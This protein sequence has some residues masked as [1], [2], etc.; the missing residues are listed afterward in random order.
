MAARACAECAHAHARDTRSLRSLVGSPE[1]P[2]F[3][4]QDATNTTKTIN[5]HK[6]A[7]ESLARFARSCAPLRL[8]HSHHKTRPTPPRQSTNTSRHRNHSLASLARVLPCGSN[9]PTTRRD[10]HH[11]DN[12]T[13]QAGAGITRS[14]RSLVCSPAA[15]TFPPQDVTR[16]LRSL[17]CSPADPHSLR[18]PS[19]SRPRSARLGFLL[20]ARGGNPRTPSA[21]HGKGLRNRPFTSLG[22]I[23]SGPPPSRSLRSLDAAP[24]RLPAAASGDASG[25]ATLGSSALPCALAI[26]PRYALIG[27]AQPVGIAHI[28]Y[29]LPP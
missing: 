24:R 28:V 15:P 23:P 22:P 20:P 16:S 11:Q 6:Q 8:Q 3:P 10:Q 29:R 12:Q 13:T 26:R 17:V 25:L 21:G 2:T 19:G 14:L 4:P 5:Q 7:Q 27:W 1:A 18:S 9:I